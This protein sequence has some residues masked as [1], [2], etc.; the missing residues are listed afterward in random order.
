[1]RPS[2][3]H[4]D[5]NNKRDCSNRAWFRCKCCGAGVCKKHKEDKC[6][7]GGERFVKI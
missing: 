2:C 6:P 4:I 1:M 3:E 7:Y 5:W